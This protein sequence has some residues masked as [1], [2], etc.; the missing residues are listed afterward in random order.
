LRVLEGG[1]FD[2]LEVEADVY[3]VQVPVPR[4]VTTADGRPGVPDLSMPVEEYVRRGPVYRWSGLIDDAQAT[5]AV[6]AEAW[7]DNRLR[8]EVR[9]RL[10]EDIQALAPDKA[11]GR[12]VWVVGFEERRHLYTVGAVVGGNRVRFARL[13]RERLREAQG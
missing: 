5:M 3:A 1:P 9:Y 2:G 10:L 4:R 11:L 12:V 7:Q 13:M 8:R 6:S